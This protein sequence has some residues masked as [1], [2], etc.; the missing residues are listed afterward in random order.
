MTS[1]NS[2]SAEKA[3]TPGEPPP[4]VEDH[5]SES[6]HTATIGGDTFAY[7][8]TA[9]RI[10]L[11]EEEGEKKASFFFV[12][13]TRDDAPDPAQRP[14]VFAFNG[15]PGS[16]S[17][18]LHLGLLGPKR[19]LLDDE[20]N[21][22]PPPGQLIDN[23][24]SILDAADLVFIDPVSTGFT[25]AIPEKEA[26]SFHHFTRDIE[27]VGSFIRLYLGRFGRWA[28]PKFLI[29][30][31]YGTTR[32][33]GL[34]GHLL[35]RYGLYLNGV[36]LISSVLNFQTIAVDKKTHMFHRGNDLPYI[37]YLP[38][39][40][41]TAWYHG[42]L[43]EDLQNRPLREVLA[44]AEAFAGGEYMA[45]LWAGA[46]LPSEQRAEIAAAVARYSGLSIEFVQRSNLRI[47]KFHFLK[48]LLRDEGHTVGRID[49]RFKGVDRYLVGSMLENDPSIDAIL[50]SFAAMLN[51]YVRR[52][53]GYESDLP[54]EI[55][56]PDVYPAWNYEDFQ[57]AYVDVSETLRST[58]SR[59]P[60][61][62]VFVASGYFD[63]ATPYFATDYTLRHL[64][65]EEALEANITERRYEAGHM[66]YIHRPSLER[67]REDLVSFIAEA[68]AE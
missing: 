57:N 12:A 58:M 23:D 67:L 28:S 4:H 27:T 41:A 10:I 17:V 44:D 25:R 24:A 60:H 3:G 30:E 54:Y 39:Y 48:E 55:L 33:A 65:L 53:L 21:Q 31:S 50:G 36:M 66:M 5:F 40:T 7:T 6:S 61:M 34:A 37:L 18:W 64:G 49:S 68:I 47:E 1:D 52:D 26:S 14:I 35:E 46:R 22:P 59:N 8:A 45:A 63:M 2:E 9:G 16:A 13:Y 42:K 43:E 51:D 19:V 15:G 62:K 11:K 38:A 56:N 32:S 29:G 20:G